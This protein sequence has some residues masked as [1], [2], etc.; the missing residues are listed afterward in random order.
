LLSLTT[1]LLPSPPPPSFQEPLLNW[2]V[3]SGWSSSYASSTL[4]ST[5]RAQTA[6]MPSGSGR[7]LIEPVGKDTHL[8]PCSFSCWGAR[9]S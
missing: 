2:S 9:S 8:N 4:P 5:S 7:C 6:R 1:P 3:S